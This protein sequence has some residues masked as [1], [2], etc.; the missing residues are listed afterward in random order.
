[1]DYSNA[2]HRRRLD[3]Y[4]KIELPLVLRAI[5]KDMFDFQDVQRRPFFC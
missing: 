3:A 2:E 1:M 4:I 5:R